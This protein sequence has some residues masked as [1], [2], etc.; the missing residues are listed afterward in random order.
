M[1]NIGIMQGRLLPRF[2]NRYQAHPIQIWPSEFYI[3]RELGFSSIE[4]ILDYDQVLKNPLMHDEGLHLIQDVINKTNVT[5]NSICADYFM[6]APFHSDYQSDSE[7]LLIELIDNAEKINIKDIVIPCVDESSLKN[8]LD[9]DKLH[10][11]L[12]KILPIAE[13]K[14]IYIN[15]ETD[16]QPLKLYD[17]ISNFNSNNIKI[18]YDSGNSSSLGYDINEEF[19]LYGNYI[20]D[21]HIKDRKLNGESVTLG[22]GDADI[23]QL[24]NLI[25]TYNLEK[26][27]IM[28]AF[29]EYDYIADIN[30]VIKQKK[31]LVDLINEVNN[32]KE[33]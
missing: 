9:M 11:S 22:S 15:L 8:D 18:N 12:S 27:I 30:S 23:K 19:E 5:V 20:S 24:L 14:N 26:N 28:Q 1:I 10:Q 21:V 31:Y 33:I 4:F 13:E 16:L 2:N 17:F 7:K 32:D 6:H 3:A 29:R 25:Y